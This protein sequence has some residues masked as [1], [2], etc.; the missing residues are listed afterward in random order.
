MTVKDKILSKSIL[1]GRG[2]VSEVIYV[3]NKGELPK[4]KVSN[5]IKLLT[6]IDK[7][8]IHNASLSKSNII[9]NEIEFIVIDK[10]IKW[11]SKIEE[12]YKYISKNYDTLPKY[13]LYLDGTDTLIINDIDN[14]KE[15]LDYYSCKVLFNSE[16]DFWHTGTQAPK[17]FPKYYEKLQYE[18]KSK[19]VE[20][21]KIKYGLDKYYHQSLNAGV[22]LGEKE[23]VFKLLEECLELMND[24]YRKGYPYGDTDDQLLLRYFHN[25][26][27]ED[28][29]ID[30]FHKTMFW[31]TSESFKDKENILSPDILYKEKIK[32]EKIKGYEQ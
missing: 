15:I 9:N 5:D 11:I 1:H 32:Y 6:V 31:G 4:V 22:F 8:A 10:Y 3:I 17:D 28:I 2:V 21:N 7:G 20:K 26:Y 25:K 12:M 16:P 13:I 14:P 27:F 23:Y 19:Y 30:L 18:I 29:S 24:D